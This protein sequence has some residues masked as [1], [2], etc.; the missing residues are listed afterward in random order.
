MKKERMKNMKK[1]LCMILSLLMLVSASVAASAEDTSTEPERAPHAGV[2][3][4][5]P[6]KYK[7]LKGHIEFDGGG[8]L[9]TDDLGIVHFQMYYYGVK[10]EDMEA[11]N[12]FSNAYF[13]ALL[14][15]RELP[16]APNPAWQEMNIFTVVFEVFAI[17]GG[18]GE[19]E[20]RA[21]LKENN[22]WRADDC[23]VF[24]EIGKEGDFTFYLVQYA[25][26]EEDDDTY[27]KVM[28]EFYDEF[29]SV[30]S[31]KETFLSGLTLSEPE[32]VNLTGANGKVSYETTDLAGNPV[33]S[34]EL[35]ADHKVTM[36][37]LWAT[38]CVPCK[39]EL[40]ELQPMSEAFEAKGCQLVGICLDAS[41]EGK[42]EEALSILQ[43]AGVKYLNLVG[44]DEI[45]EQMNSLGIPVS[46]FLDS[47]GNILTEP[48][49]GAYLELYPERLEE[50]L[51]IVG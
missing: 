34:E 17:D 21:F 39:K 5:L 49:E 3:Y 1:L 41:E 22:G 48:V 18:R 43:D 35:F 10:D 50:A 11:F 8:P 4:T 19:E 33:T 7:N 46:F 42:T 38:W 47:E 13:D 25:E 26:L 28:G 16:E 23:R 51:A 29:V 27:R 45:R 24:E 12:D 20:L 2:T 37:N 6:E 30:Y 32:P 36:V 14:E 40:P 15:G 31:D 9:S 44:T